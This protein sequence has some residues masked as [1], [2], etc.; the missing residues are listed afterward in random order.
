MTLPARP[1]TYRRTSAG[2]AGGRAPRRSRRWRGF[3]LI[4]LLVVVAILS[5]LMG[6][7]LPSLNRAKALSRETVCRTNL[8]SIYLAQSAYVYENRRFQPLN[9]DQDDGAWQYNYLIYDGR[10]FDQNFG[11]LIS[12]PSL[13]HDVRLLYCPFQK[14]LSH[15]LNT[16]L[17]PWPTAPSLDTRAAYARRYRLTGKDLTR[18]QNTVGMFADLIHLPSVVKAAHRTGVNAVYSDGH[19]AWVPDPGIFTNNDL[20]TPFDPLDNPI[21]KEIWQAIDKGQ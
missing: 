14:A 4:E 3:T 9:N 12:D 19:A 6:I 8:R 11:P 16:P 5:V 20:G 21:I 2:P 15:R 10:D 7:L 18:Y 1:P 13:L 17:N